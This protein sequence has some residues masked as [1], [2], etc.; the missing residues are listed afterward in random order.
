LIVNIAIKDIIL[1]TNNI[2]IYNAKSTVCENDNDEDM[3]VILFFFVKT[4]FV[5]E[6]FT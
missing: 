4:S 5:D 6:N 3:Y 1:S 2:E